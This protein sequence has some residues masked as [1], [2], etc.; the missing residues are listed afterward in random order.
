MGSIVY[1][2]YVFLELVLEAA[3]WEGGGGG[4]REE[5]DFSIH[6]TIDYYGPQF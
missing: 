5:G 3:G 1:G 6:V 2:T 4:R